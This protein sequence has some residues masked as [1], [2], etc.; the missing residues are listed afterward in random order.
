MSF[1]WNENDVTSHFIRGKYRE[2]TQLI[3]PS[4]DEI[5]KAYEVLLA[6][7]DRDS[8]RFFRIEDTRRAADRG[9]AE[10]VYQHLFL[11]AYNWL[12]FF[13]WTSAFKTRQLTSGLVSAYNDNNFLAWLILGRSSL[14]YAAVSYYFV[15]QINQ[16]ELRGPVFAAS[17]VQRLEELLMK[18]AHGTRF[19]WPD[20]FSGN[21]DGLAKKFISTDS[22][23]AINVMT[24]LE[25]LAQRDHR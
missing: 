10:Q 5:E 8:A 17:H 7:P 22:S 6:L 19:N 3:G 11:D 2:E 25:H 9:S 18:Y 21:R 14:E 13:W 4:L 20:L 23:A 1:A 15:K 16:L 24:A 12:K